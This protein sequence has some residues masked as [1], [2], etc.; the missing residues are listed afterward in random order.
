MQLAGGVNLNFITHWYSALPQTITF[1][2]PGAAE[3]I[4]Q[5]DTAGDGQTTLAP[6]PGS[7]I[8]SFGR[9]I[10]A[11]DLN[12]F[13]ESYSDKFGNQL[14]PAGQA[15]VTAGLFSQTQLEQ[16]CAVTPSLAPI[17][18]CATLEPQLQL[19]PAPSGNI[20]NDAFFT[21]DLGLGWA[22]RPVKRIER[23]T[24]EPKVTF[25]NIFNRHNYNG[26]DATLAGTLDGGAT[27]I[28]G[29][30][31]SS[32]LP[33]LTGLGS[34]VFAIGAPRSMEFGIKVSF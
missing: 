6:V 26:P 29:A 17:G 24:I 21:F 23:F 13:L 27:S 7:N 25:Y 3:D 22:I 18:N 20:A 12:S 4:F 34:G 1:A 19:T 16:L 15:L 2:A 9:D 10:K 33:L 32:R 28:N 30:T 31:K 8:G 14:T 11:G 5:F